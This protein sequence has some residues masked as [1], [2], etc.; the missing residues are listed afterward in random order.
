M[1][2]GNR[3]LQIFRHFSVVQNAHKV[4]MINGVFASGGSIL[5][6]QEVTFWLLRG[7]LWHAQ[8]PPLTSQ[9]ASFR[10]T[11]GKKRQISPLFF[12]FHF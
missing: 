7:G 12:A 6:H 3:R 11:E 8:R 5:V 1:L 2:R 10:K 4:G 9:K